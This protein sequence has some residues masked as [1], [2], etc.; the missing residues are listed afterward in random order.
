M[1]QLWCVTLPLGYGGIETVARMT[2]NRVDQLSIVQKG[3]AADLVE[4]VQ[5]A[6]VLALLAGSSMGAPLLDRAKRLGGSS[7]LVTAGEGAAAAVACVVLVAACTSLQGD[8][9]VPDGTVRGTLGEDTGPDKLGLMIAATVLAPALEELVYRGVLLAGFV[10]NM[11][12]PVAVILS[13]VAFAGSHFSASNF[14]PLTCLGVCLG[15]LYIL[16]G[17]S[18]AK[19]FVA[20]SM[21]NLIVLILA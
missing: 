5:L 9:P 20:H 15:S 13:S 19:C 3:M 10:G 1:V 6:A 21:Y 17:K 16:G 7:W 2:S 18:V 14:I 8:T 4:V 12:S 11:S